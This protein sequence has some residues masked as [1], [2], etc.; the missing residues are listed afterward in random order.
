MVGLVIFNNNYICNHRNHFLLWYEGS[1]KG[2]PHVTVPEAPTDQETAL[3]L[4]SDH[5]QTSPVN[6][7]HR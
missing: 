5:A 3:I 7:F 4:M 1:I 6:I 2:A